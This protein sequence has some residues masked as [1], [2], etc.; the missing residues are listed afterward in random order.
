MTRNCQKLKMRKPINNIKVTA[1]IST[2]HVWNSV[3]SIHTTNSAS[4][5][6]CVWRGGALTVHL[7]LLCLPV[8]WLYRIN[9]PTIRNKGVAY[10]LYLYQGSNLC[11]DILATP[12]HPVFPHVTGQISRWFNPFPILLIQ[13]VFLT[14]TFCTENSESFPINSDYRRQDYLNTHSNTSA[15]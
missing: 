4:T 5:C 15:T 11:L 8:W 2:Q 10:C 7:P 9:T 1:S 6:V 13:T 3:L 12:L 14:N